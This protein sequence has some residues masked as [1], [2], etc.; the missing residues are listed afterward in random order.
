MHKVP[1]ADWKS[2][3][4]NFYRQSAEE[5]ARLWSQL[6]PEQQAAFIATHNAVQTPT[7]PAERSKRTIKEELDDLIRIGNDLLS[8]STFS[9][10]KMTRYQEYT[11]WRLR[12]L[13]ALRE[14]G[15]PAE[16]LLSTVENKY[17]QNFL[18]QFAQQILGAMVAARTI[19]ERSD[20]VERSHTAGRPGATVTFD[21][22]VFVV[23]G[24]DHA[25]LQ[26]VVRL[27]ERLE[28]KPIVLVEEPSRGRTI[29]E[30]LEEQSKTSVAIIILTPDDIGAPAAQPD[31]MKPR[32]RQNVILELGYFLGVL[33]RERVIV[34]YTDGVE[35]PSDYVGVEYIR[36]DKEGGWR[37]KVARELRAANLEVDLNKLDS[38][39]QKT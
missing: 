4:D 22:S 17:T 6:T 20:G 16:H 10:M 30:K 9:M 19:A 12:C 26:Q 5:Q 8:I 34:L 36:L 15:Q 24:H 25:A 23:H 28:L 13:G 11:A 31:A 7:A 21:R 32:A 29:I 37:L 38:G 3:L 27:I 2:Y 33:G 1:M 18:K 35:L 39:T 14:L